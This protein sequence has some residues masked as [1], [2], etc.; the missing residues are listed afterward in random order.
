M[1]NSSL[2]VTGDLIVIAASLG[3]VILAAVIIFFIVVK[4]QTAARRKKIEGYGRESE[5]RIDSLLKKAFGDDAVF[6]GIYL[7]YLN[8]EN[9]KHAEIDHL[10]ITRSGI[11]VVEVKSHNGYIRC[12]DERYWWQTYNEKKIS[13]YNPLRQNKTHS[14]IVTEILKT[15]GQYKVPVYSVVV[16]TSHRVT[17]SHTYPNVIKESELVSYIKKNGRKNALTTTQTRRI[18]GLISHTAQKTAKDKSVARRHKR[19]V[20]K[21]R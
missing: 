9:K 16:F 21:Y 19:S 13:F 7:P 2:I 4:I 11:C 3:A 8:S 18:R 5:I 10:V 12:P 20:R 6:S 17:F 1:F 15:E 14:K